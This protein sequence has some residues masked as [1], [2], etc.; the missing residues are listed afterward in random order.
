[1][2][3]ANRKPFSRII[4][5]RF[6]GSKLELPPSTITRPAKDNVREAIF[7]RLSF[8]KKYDG[9]SLLE[10]AHV[11]DVFAG[12]AS[13][14]LEALS[15]GAAMLY[16]IDQNSQVISV[17]ERNIKKLDAI[18]QVRI[19]KGDALQPTLAPGVMDVAFI[20]PPYFQGLVV[21]TLK[22][23]RCQGWIAAKTTI[24]AE[25]DKEE[26]IALPDGFCVADQ[27]TY[28]RVKILEI[29]FAG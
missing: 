6:R 15:R 7:N 16:L 28:G 18:K 22:A 4:S 23:L 12:S 1:M 8:R 19:I 27:R 5:G 25:V 2:K 26:V 9:S 3:K 11:V 21:P 13:M 24:L 10:N 29:S 20:D 14:G 17:I